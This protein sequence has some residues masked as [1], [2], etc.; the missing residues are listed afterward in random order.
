[1]ETQ[2]M[3][4][5]IHR[6]DLDRMVT[7]VIRISAVIYVGLGLKVFEHHMD[8]HS[9]AKGQ[10]RLMGKRLVLQVFHHKL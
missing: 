4:L 10:Q 1:M 8:A 6:P 3:S 9:R 5:R 2:L 7:Q